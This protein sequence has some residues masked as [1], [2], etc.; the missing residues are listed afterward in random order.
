[1]QIGR[2]ITSILFFCFLSVTAQKRIDGSVVNSKNGNS[3]TF[4][5]I[6]IDGAFATLSDLKGNFSFEVKSLPVTISAK[7]IGFSS[8]EVRIDENTPMPIRLELTPSAEKIEEVTISSSSKAKEIIAR[9]IQNIPDNDP[10]QRLNQ[11]GYTSYEKLII[12][13]KNEAQLTE[14]DTSQ[15]DLKIL[16]NKAHSFISETVSTYEYEKGKGEKR[17]IQGTKMSGFREP[18]YDVYGMTI[19][20]NSLYKNKYVIFNNEYASPL[21]KNVFRNYFYRVLD[22]IPG[23]HPSYVISFQPKRSGKIASLEGVLYLDQKTL[24]LQKARIE[25]N[26]NIAIKANYTYTYLPKEELWF[27][28]ATDVQITP[29][30]GR[31]KVSLF[32][33]SVRVGSLDTKRRTDLNRALLRLTSI[34][35]DFK[36]NILEPIQFAPTEIKIDPEAQE[37]NE[38]YWQKYRP[39]SLTTRD[40]LSYQ[41]VDSIVKEQ[42]IERKINVAQRFSIGYYPI[43]FMDFDLRYPLKFNNF[44]G[45]RTGMGGVTN[46]KLSR[47]FRLEGY[48]VYGFKDRT[49]KF[50]IGGGFRLKP[51]SGT[52]LNINY[53]DDIAEVGSFFYLTDRRVYS[54][55][56]P[57]LVNITD[58]YRFTRW[59]TSL[60]YRMLPNVLSETQFSRS[61]VAP[62]TAYTFDSGNRILSDYEITEATVSL[63]WSPFSTYLRAPSGLR[64]VYDGYPKIS[65]QVTQALPDVLEGDFDYT[66]VGVKFEYNVMRLNQSHTSLLLEGDWGFGQIPLTHTFHTYPNAPVKETI[67]QR[68]SVAGRR[69][70]ETMFFGEFYSTRL[71]TAQLRHGLRPFGISRIFRP[72]LVLI[73]RAAIGD[74]PDQER[75][76]NVVFNTLEHGFLESG[77][78]LNKIFAGFGV[79]LFYRYGAYHL[80]TF[81]DNISFKFTFYLQ[82]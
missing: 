34:Y 15:A 59:Q 69:S 81:E 67:M 50:S 30:Q 47:R 71:A 66:K 40:Q 9:A 35:S 7:F 43:G 19:Q 61:S 25:L 52:W 72:Q 54:L 57:R 56:E 80:P 79:G 20:S 41:V 62:T 65:A 44:E 82:L 39:D 42:K 37:R 73:S 22:T 51:N 48:W 31:Q 5:T 17:F 63:R 60:Q 26:G 18:I 77:F 78:E 64:E 70:F 29:G 74:L 45:L 3:L 27:P 11:Y 49:A 12:T 76:Q 23:E 21:G 13:S 33:G 75:H 4:A 68:F 2:F 36:P 10:E 32:G 28:S 1:M 53:T 16:F 58:Y 55:F 8:K 24:A 6:R 38:A 14:T 46:S